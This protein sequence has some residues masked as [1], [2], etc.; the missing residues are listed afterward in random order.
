VSF[1]HGAGT[2]PYEKLNLK[3]NSIGQFEEKELS[4]MTVLNC[5]EFCG[6]IVSA[7]WKG[8]TV[9]EARDLMRERGAISIT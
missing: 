8:T 2:G 3:R 1:S 7:V 5:L 4:K 9:L 6:R